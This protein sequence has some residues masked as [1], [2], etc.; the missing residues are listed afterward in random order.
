MQKKG[1]FARLF[2]LW[3]G[4]FGVRI[5]DAEVRNAEV[6]YHNA[7]EERAAQHRTLK[8]AVGRL[9][10]LR[11]RLDQQIQRAAG[12]LAVVEGALQRAAAEG[13]DAR[14]LALIRKRRALTSELERLRGEHARVQVQADEAKEGLRQLA[15][16]IRRLKE[17]RTEMLARKAHAMARIEVAETLRAASGDF[18]ASGQA[19]ENVREAIARLE[20]QADLGHE[21]DHEGVGDVSLSELRR[22]AEDEADLAELEELKRRA[23]GRFLEERTTTAQGITPVLTPTPAEVLG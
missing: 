22:S 18:T 2:D 9:V 21:A 6:V 4:M 23:N 13:D 15:D 20:Y 16:A 1:F 11:N 14:S 3:R 10:Y 8:D 12:D 5:R 17:E 7:I 19:L